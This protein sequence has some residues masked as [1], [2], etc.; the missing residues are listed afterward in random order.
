MGRAA[1]GREGP[2]LQLLVGAVL[3][4]ASV[5]VLAAM[6]SSLDRRVPFLVFFPA[7]TAS[8]WLGGFGAGLASTLLGAGSV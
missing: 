7:V 1:R 5:L 8:A 4:G 3:V 2:L 6:A